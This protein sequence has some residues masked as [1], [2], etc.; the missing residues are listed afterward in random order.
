[1]KSE[2]YVLIDHEVMQCWRCMLFILI[3]NNFISVT[4]YSPNLS[5]YVADCGVPSYMELFI[6]L[7][8]GF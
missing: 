8:S 6:Y 5:L 4:D 7:F 1:M 2:P 3:S